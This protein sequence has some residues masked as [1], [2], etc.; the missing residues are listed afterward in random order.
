MLLQWQAK[1]FSI[2]KIGFY[3]IGE[4]MVTRLDL[5]KKEMEKP[6]EIYAR[7]IEDFSKRYPALGKMTIAEEPDIDVQEYIFSFE[8]LDG[9]SQDE[10]DKI[11][12]EISDHMDE[13]SKRQGIERFSKWAVIWLQFGELY[14]Y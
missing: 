3:T 13:F 4:T 9:T 10:L 2:E 7:E 5:F 1:L 14:E 6:K 11:Y 8:N 12:L